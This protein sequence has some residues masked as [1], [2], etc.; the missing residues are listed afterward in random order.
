MGRNLDR[1]IEVACP[2][3]AKDI[4]KEI[5]D[6]IEIQLKDNVKARIINEEQDNKYVSTKS[7]TEFRS[8]FALYDYYKRKLFDN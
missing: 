4:Q 8:Q 2:V 3:Y 1:R 7:S 5:K 6:L